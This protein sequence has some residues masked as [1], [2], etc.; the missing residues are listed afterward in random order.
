MR[1]PFRFIKFGILS[2]FFVEIN[3]LL[4]CEHTRVWEGIQKNAI[5]LIEFLNLSY[6]K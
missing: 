2:G 1:F 5:K 6:A 3:I 4:V